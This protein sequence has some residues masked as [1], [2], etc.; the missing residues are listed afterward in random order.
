MKKRNFKPLALSLLLAGLYGATTVGTTFAL[1]TD[2]AETKIEVTAGKVD[3]QSSVKLIKYTDGSLEH[4]DHTFVENETSY[5]TPKVGTK[6]VVEG[7]TLTITNMVPGDKIELDVALKNFS[8]V[9][10]KYRLHITNDAGD[11][12]DALTVTNTGGKEKWTLLNPAANQTAGDPVETARIAI[13]FVNHD[14]GI[15]ARED[16][17]SRDNRFM[18]KTVTF[19]LDYE[20]VQGNAAV[21]D[22]VTG[23]NVDYTYIT[24]ASDGDDVGTNTKVDADFEEII[25]APSDSKLGNGCILSLKRDVTLTKDLYINPYDKNRAGDILIVSNGFSINANGHKIYLGRNLGVYFDKYVTDL[26]VKDPSLVNWFDSSQGK[27]EDYNFQ[28]EEDQSLGAYKYY[29]NVTY[30]R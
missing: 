5:T 11:L 13:E 16:A 4:D 21:V 29:V 12:V 24:Y 18:G 23:K 9:K 26:F 8:N 22:D 20:V 19:N 15:L 27:G 30:V 6:F 3:I 14:D 28:I 17:A 7:S 10:T 25:S 1:F 2:K